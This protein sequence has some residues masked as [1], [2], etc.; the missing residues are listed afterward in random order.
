MIRR[1]LIVAPNSRLAEEWFSLWFIK[2]YP[3]YDLTCL[4]VT[5]K[6]D[7]EEEWLVKFEEV[8]R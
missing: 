8:P 4:Q 6:H 7:S 5:K 2:N 1:K 3:D